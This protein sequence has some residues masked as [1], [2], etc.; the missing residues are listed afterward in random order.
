MV[1]IW[2][3][4]RQ[5]AKLDD[6]AAPVAVRG[7]GVRDF[8]ELGKPRL[9]GLVIFTAGIGVWMGGGSIGA[10]AAATF[11]L[12]TACLVAAANAL[13]CWIE[14]EIDALMERTRGRPLPAGRMEPRLALAFG[15]ALATLSLTVLAV[16]T[17]PL[18][19]ALGAIALFSYVFVYTPMKRLSP[20]A[21][22]V[23]AVPGALP[24]LMG[25]TA[26]T[27]RIS[28]QG[29]LLFAIL[30][31][32]QL[33]HFLAISLNLKEDF[34]SGGI[35]VL[36][37]VAGD[38]VTRY[39]LFAST[40]L[41]AGVSIAAQP[42][43]IAGSAYTVVATVLSVIFVTLAIPGLRREVSGDW[44]RRIFRFTLVQLPI[45]IT[46]LVLGAS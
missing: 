29:L 41:L 26:A 13:N 38:R 45:L 46:A 17:N 18:T 4:M 21:L 2:G 9:S 20:W 40:L 5:A 30:F 23:G 37:L 33:P 19:V 10:V 39:C 44:S 16:V 32:W 27:G 43:G 36:S 8:V 12:A 14:V 7:T 22:L 6:W 35:R 34:R 25:W 24:P 3:P 28:T 31:C 15:V 42:L 1:Y 11:V